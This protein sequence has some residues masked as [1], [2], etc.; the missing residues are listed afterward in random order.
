MGED[1]KTPTVKTT[2]PLQQVAEWFLQKGAQQKK[3]SKLSAWAVGLLIGGL[4]LLVVG[5]MYF[6]VWRKGAQL[7]KLL[8]ERDL[9]REKAKA[10][11]IAAETEK[12]Q[13][14]V[15]LLRTEAVAALKHV[16]ALDDEIRKVEDD[17]AQVLASIDALKSWDDVDRYLSGGG[18]SPR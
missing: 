14:K 18:N 2:P 10:S 5:A 15:D 11:A 4:A 16:G 12:A 9:A 3:R 13:Q 7:A 17:K 6:F 8:H 1:D